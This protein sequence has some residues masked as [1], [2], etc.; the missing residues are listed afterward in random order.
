MFTFR[1]NVLNKFP[2]ATLPVLYIFILPLPTK[3]NRVPNRI[4]TPPAVEHR[5]DTNLLSNNAYLKAG[6]PFFYLDIVL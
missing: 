5:C 2:R 1:R 6:D 4:L 3:V